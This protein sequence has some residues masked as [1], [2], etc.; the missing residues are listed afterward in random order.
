MLTTIVAVLCS[1]VALAF[2]VA[3]AVGLWSTSPRHKTR[4][5]KG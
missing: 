2:V 1:L 3:L 4:K 5:P